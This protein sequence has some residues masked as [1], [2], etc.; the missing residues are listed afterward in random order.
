MRDFK[1]YEVWQNAHSLTLKIFDL[2]KSFPE[3]EKYRL[4]SQMLRAAYSIPSNFAEGCGRQSDKDFDRFLQICLGSAH[5][6]EYFLILCNDINLISSISY[7]LLTK[8]INIV[9]MQLFNLS[10]KLKGI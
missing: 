1:K 8:D 10:K 2:T 6:L 5:E 3:D 7:D 9:K 4:T